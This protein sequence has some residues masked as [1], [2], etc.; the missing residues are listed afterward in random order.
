MK[1]DKDDESHNSTLNM[2]VIRCFAC[3]S[4]V[5]DHTVS[6]MMSLQD[7][8]VLALRTMQNL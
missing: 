8:I 7:V 2:C 5:I 1:A 3:F 6:D 4:M